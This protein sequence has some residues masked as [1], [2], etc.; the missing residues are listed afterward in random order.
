LSLS[1]Q[2]EYFTFDRVITDWRNCVLFF[3]GH[4]LLLNDLIKSH[5]SPF[6]LFDELIFLALLI[7]L[8]C[9]VYL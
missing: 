7:I 4:M 3:F 6:L 9:M 1:E 5:N 2:R 8:L